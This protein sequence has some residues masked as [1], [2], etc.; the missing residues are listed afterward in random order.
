MKLNKIKNSIY[1]SPEP[2]FK[3]SLVTGSYCITLFRKQAFWSFS[4]EH[5]VSRNMNY[6]FPG[7][8]KTNASYSD[9]ANLSCQEERKQESSP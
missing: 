8:S 1:Q 6:I 7:A 4:L 5:F 9:A 2:N 3:H